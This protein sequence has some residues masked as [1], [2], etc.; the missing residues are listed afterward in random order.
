MVTD[1]PVVEH[2]EPGDFRGVALHQLT[3]PAQ[4]PGPLRRPPAAPRRVRGVR[5]AH[6]GVD[7]VGT[8]Q[9]HRSLDLTSGRKHVLVHAARA[10]RSCLAADVQMHFGNGQVNGHRSVLRSQGAQGR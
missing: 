10:L 2:R 9:R 5:G 3:E 6:G 1:I 7:V 8:G 4:H